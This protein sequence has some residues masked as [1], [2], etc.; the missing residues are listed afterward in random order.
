VLRTLTLLLGMAGVVGFSPSPATAA[1][2]VATAVSSNWS[3]YS[4]TG[5]S[6]SSVSGS[7]VQPAATCTRGS[8]GY[9]A[10][11]VGL[12]GFD[13]S[14]QALEQI[15]TSADC[16]ASGSTS[17]TAWYELVPAASVT[18]PLSVSPGD[19]VSASVAVSGTTVTLQLQNATTGASF[20]KTLTIASPDVGSAEWIAEAPSACT[21][22]GNGCRGL[23][24]ANFGTIAFSSSSATAAGHT[25][26][27]S[28]PAWS[29]T[30]IQLQSSSGSFRRFALIGAGGASP[31]AL[32]IDGSS[33]SVAWQ[34]ALALPRRSR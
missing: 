23:P 7:W 27:V 22:S 6:F 14:S 24:L 16:S 17:Y 28:D 8:S 19:T 11:W 25:G 4:V 15:G 34:Q 30:A 9:S 32:S 20:A 13:P 3:G 5:T 21:A 12:G 10:F 26:T 31:S 29:A 33:F 1:A 2:T 18:V